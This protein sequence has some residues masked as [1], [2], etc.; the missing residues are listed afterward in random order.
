MTQTMGKGG[1]SVP[2]H[3]LRIIPTPT[4]KQGWPLLLQNEITEKNMDEFVAMVVF[5]D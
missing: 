4:G 3:W 5:R 1:S 2:L